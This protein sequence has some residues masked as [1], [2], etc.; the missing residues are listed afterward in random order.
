M[1]TDE[2]LTIAHSSTFNALAG[3]RVV[4]SEL[5]HYLMYSVRHQ[6]L[7]SHILLAV[8]LN[9]TSEFSCFFQVSGIHGFSLLSPEVK[10]WHFNKLSGKDYDCISS[11][12]ALASKP[13]STRCQLY[14]DGVRR[15]LRV[16]VA[17]GASSL[18]SICHPPVSGLF[19]EATL[20][21]PILIIST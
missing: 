1:R 13:H 16:S 14:K 11:Q 15:C 10:L 3:L 21:L 5:T 12:R 17:V 6:S 20:T 7:S 8:L 2:K 4:R 9:Q 19:P 18:T